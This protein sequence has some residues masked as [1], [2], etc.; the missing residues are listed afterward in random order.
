MK[1]KISRTPAWARFAAI[2]LALTLLLGG[3]L[4][5][6]AA[7]QDDWWN[8]LLLGG[9]S[10]SSEQY[11]RT[12]S[13]IILSVNRQSGAL[14]MTS[15]MRDTWVSFPGRES[16]GKINAANVY[17]GPELAMATVNA[18]FGTQIED[19]AL[20]NM[21][22]LVK[23]VDALDGVDIEITSTELKYLNEY[24]RGFA[25]TIGD[26]GETQLAGAGLAHLNGLLALSYARIRYADSDYQRAMRQQTVLLALAKKAS[27]LSAPELLKLVPKLLGMTDTNLSMGEA[28]ALATLCAGRDMDE[29]RQ[30]RIPVDGTFQ[31]GMFGGTW[32]IKP[33][34]EENAR[35]LH[36]FIYESE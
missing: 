31:S 6:P 30:Y 35:L 13:I 21:T 17:G 24:A 36:D 23:V 16:K 22:G 1:K 8:I 25:D 19:Y 29:I 11:D 9:D 10:R 12:D 5:E 4:A 18:S 34:F 33:D 15:V 28:M 20:V 14:K 27:A 2:L 3:A 7:A 26:E 32:C